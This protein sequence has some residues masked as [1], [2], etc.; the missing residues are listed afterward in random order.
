[1]PRTRPP[2]SQSLHDVARRFVG[3]DP[4]LRVEPLGAGLINATYR[5]ESAQ[6]SFVLQRINE[7]VFP[8]PEHIMSNLTR[9]H[10][11]AAARQELGVRLPTP[12][13]A[14]DGAAFVRASDDGIWRMMEYVSPSRTLSDVQNQAQAAEIGRAL[15]RFHRLGSHLD[16]RDMQVTLPGFHHTPGYLAALDQALATTG[17]RAS[18]PS[19]DA[20]IADALAFIEARRA[21]VPVLDDALRAGL[22]TVR[23]IHGDPKLD[24]LLFDQA[25]DRALCLI[26]LDTVQPGLLHHDIGDCLRSCCNRAGEA[27]DAGTP[28]Q[29]D[30]DVCSG[31]LGAYGAETR[32]LLST[33]EVALIYPCI[34][35]IPL[36]LGL[37][38]LTDHLRGDRYFRVTA[39]GDNLRKAQGQF[40]LVA[41]IERKAKS[42]GAI[43]TRSF[44]RERTTYQSNGGPWQ[45]NRDARPAI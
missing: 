37:R 24:N 25:N 10:A 42:I 1:M 38:F 39:P 22:T 31:I 9:L 32:G 16:P 29:F 11:L 44:Q 36:E 4:T 27:T 33:A 43:I 17:Y 8:A 12:C 34:R 35:L 15:G 26:D 28:V 2:A 7:A 23:V 5:V 3:D 21:L 6:G 13:P 40:A 41:D 19:A 18:A 45:G 14:D 20:R 30:L